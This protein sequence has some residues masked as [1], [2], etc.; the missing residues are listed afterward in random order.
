M[1][2][3]MYEIAKKQKK[4][5]PK[6]D[7]LHLRNVRRKKKTIETHIPLLLGLDTKTNLS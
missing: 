5:T 3:K 7:E 4:C 1:E 6:G 2:G